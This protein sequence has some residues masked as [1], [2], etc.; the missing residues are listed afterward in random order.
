MHLVGARLRAEG[1]E[2]SPSADPSTLLRRVWL[3]L[4]GLPPPAAEVESFQNDHSIEAWS[5][6]ST[7]CSTIRTS[8]NAGRGTGWM[9]RDMRISRVRKGHGA[10][11]GVDS[12]ATGSS[13]R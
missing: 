7:G 8:A 10:L 2:F 5:D 11:L 6:S 1:M 12:S 3:D 4:V 9:P 13:M